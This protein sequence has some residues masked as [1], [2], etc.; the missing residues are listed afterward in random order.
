[1]QTEMWCKERSSKYPVNSNLEKM[2]GEV[3]IEFLK[4]FHLEQSWRK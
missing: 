4:V 3:E 1:M 2:I